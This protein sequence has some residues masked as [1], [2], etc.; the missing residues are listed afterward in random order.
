MFN[1][2][3]LY[4]LQLLGSLGILLTLPSP[5]VLLPTHQQITRAISDLI[6]T[7]AGA[8][9]TQHDWWTLVY[10]LEGIGTGSNHQASGVPTWSPF[11]SAKVDSSSQTS[12]TRADTSTLPAASN[13]SNTVALFLEENLCKF[14]VLVEEGIRPHN[15]DIFFQCCKTLSDLVRSDVHVTPANFSACVHCI[16][17]FSEV[18]SC[19]FALEHEASMGRLVAEWV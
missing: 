16:R 9:K 5:T 11:H 12:D 4:T 19:G 2:D 13:S 6:Q 10:L 14:D 1:V 8:V 15:P 17:T 18:S 3:L 7:Q